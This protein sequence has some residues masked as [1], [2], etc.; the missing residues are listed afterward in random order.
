MI[1]NSIVPL[2][3]PCPLPMPISTLSLAP[4]HISQLWTTDLKCRDDK[5]LFFIQGNRLF[6]FF[7][8]FFLLLPVRGHTGSLLCLLWKDLRASPLE[9]SQGMGRDP[10]W[11]ATLMMALNL[12]FA[13]G[14]LLCSAP[15]AYYC[16][17]R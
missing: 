1:Y 13:C 2:R 10:G 5:G 11:H 12:G 8:S 6:F 17:W 9:M 14:F 16:R 15:Y 4:V 7:S 3:S